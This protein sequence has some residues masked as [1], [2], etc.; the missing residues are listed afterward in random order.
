MYFI[1]VSY[2]LVNNKIAN[3]KFNLILNNLV[4]FNNNIKLKNIN[5][6]LDSYG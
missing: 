2:C 4:Q 5:I 6:N 1:S 3:L